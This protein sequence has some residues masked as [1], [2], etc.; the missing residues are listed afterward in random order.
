MVVEVLIAA[1]VYVLAF[2]VAAVVDVLAFE[3]V[4]MVVISVFIVFIDMAAV[5]VLAFVVVVG[6]SAFVHGGECLFN[7]IMVNLN[8]ILSL[9]SPANSGGS[10]RPR[11]TQR[12]GFISSEDTLVAA[13]K[14]DAVVSSCSSGLRVKDMT[15]DH[16]DDGGLGG[17]LVS[18]VIN[19]MEGSLRDTIRVELN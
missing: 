4:A 1:M 11:V 13:P 9:Q 12:L 16:D 10:A 2:E 8:Q 6:Y 5:E 7:K 18:T 3:V 17:A 15:F 19:A 14:I